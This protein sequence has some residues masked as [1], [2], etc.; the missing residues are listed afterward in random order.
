MLSI[1]WH[2]PDRNYAVIID[3]AH[4]S[5]GGKASTKLKEVLAAKSLDDA[6]EQDRDDYTSDDYIREEIE[7]MRRIGG[8]A[9]ISFL[10]YRYTKI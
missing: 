9:N 4:S 5:Q 2:I 7:K 1:R 6:E 10:L 8:Q 3:E